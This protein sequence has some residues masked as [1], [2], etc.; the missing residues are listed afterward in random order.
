MWNL[1][2]PV[3]GVTRDW[4]IGG[5]DWDFEPISP[6]IPDEDA[7]QEIFDTGN[8]TGE[9]QARIQHNAF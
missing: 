1:D 2:G 6:Y 3:D 7:E 5:E 9:T 8:E 4:S